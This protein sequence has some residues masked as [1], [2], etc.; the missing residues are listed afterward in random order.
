MAA[1]DLPVSEEEALLR[2]KPVDL[3]ERLFA[4]A[5]M[6]AISAIR[7]PP[8]S[9]MFS[10]SVSFPLRWTSP[11]RCIPEYCLIDAFGAAL[12]FLG[13]L[14]RPPILQIALAIEAPARIVETVRHLMPDHRA[15]TAVIDG[16]VQL[17][18]EEG[19]LQNARG[20]IDV[21]LLRRI[22]RI[23]R[24]WRHAPFFRIRRLADLVQ[25]TAILKP[26]ARSLLPKASAGRP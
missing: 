2:S 24:G 22:V 4:I 15:D 18:I 7:T 1:P 23:H 16:I 26:S 14:L 5:S 20:E 13:V 21:V 9:A 10:P 12:E 6:N 19:R 3:R 17:R 11:S 8:L 25:I